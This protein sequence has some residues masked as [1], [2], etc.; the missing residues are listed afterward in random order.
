MRALLF[1]VGPEWFALPLSAVR[2][3][4]PSQTVTRLPGSPPWLHGLTN[5]RGELVP[6]IDVAIRIGLPATEVATH[7]AVLE[8]EEG[9]AGIGTTGPAETVVLGDPMSDAD[10]AVAIARYAVDDRV[11]T[12]LHLEGLVGAGA[13]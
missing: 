9:V 4:I 2:E 3:V 13:A 6:V 11:A 7:L 10:G 5:L 1:P 12:L 8:T